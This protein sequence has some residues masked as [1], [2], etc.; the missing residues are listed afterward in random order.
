MFMKAQIK[1]VGAHKC[2]CV[3]QVHVQ[4]QK[5]GGAFP[6]VFLYP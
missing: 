6:L 2:V 1:S 3:H 4:T 5:I